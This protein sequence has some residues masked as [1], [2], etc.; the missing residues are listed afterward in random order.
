MSSG[1]LLSQFFIESLKLFISG[2]LG[3][4]VVSF[5]NYR[6]LKA[7]KKIDAEY[8]FQER[9]LD[10]LRAIDSRLHWLY[11][12]IHYDWEKTTNKDQNPDE[13]LKELI[14]NLHYWE[15]L[16]LDDEGF[17]ITLRKLYSLIG[18]SKDE[19][20]GRNAPKKNLGEIL[21]EIRTSVRNKISEIQDG[22]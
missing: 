16:F 12:D 6:L 20:I 19:F 11:R 9:K 10:A 14:D 15:T 18:A 8:K 1:N 5:F 4:A 3:G 17:K 22:L 21:D 13:Y 7:Q 2:V